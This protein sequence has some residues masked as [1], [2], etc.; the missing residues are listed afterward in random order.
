[1]AGGDTSRSEGGSTAAEGKKWMRLAK[2]TGIYKAIKAAI[3]KDP[4]KKVKVKPDVIFPQPPQ[5]QEWEPKLYKL[6][7]STRMRVMVQYDVNKYCEVKM[8]E[9]KGGVFEVG[10]GSRAVPPSRAT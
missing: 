10:P 3:E 7:G 4:G 8:R 5:R 2:S 9:K 6:V 1:M